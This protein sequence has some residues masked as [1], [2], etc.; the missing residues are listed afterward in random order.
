MAAVTLAVHT[1]AAV[2]QLCAGR[3]VCSKPLFTCSGALVVRV[4]DVRTLVGVFWIRG[5]E[6][7][8][9]NTMIVVVVLVEWLWDKPSAY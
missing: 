4:T 5:R 1:P 3:V 6:H 8:A 2:T 7:S 9:C